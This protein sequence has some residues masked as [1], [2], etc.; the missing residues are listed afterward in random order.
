[1]AASERSSDPPAR[2]KKQA[3]HCRHTLPGVSSSVEAILQPAVAANNSNW[4]LEAG[5]L[6]RPWVPLTGA[7][8]L[9]TLLVASALATAAG[10]SR[11]A[12]TPA[13]S[14]IPEPSPHQVLP[15]SEVGADRTPTQ[16]LLPTAARKRK[17]IERFQND[18]SKVTDVVVRTPS[19]S[20]SNTAGNTRLRDRRSGS[21]G[22]AVSPRDIATVKHSEE[23]DRLGST[24]LT[25]TPEDIR[26]QPFRIPAEPSCNG[27][28]YTS[29]L[30]Y[31]REFR[32]SRS[33]NA[34]VEA[35]ED[36]A[37]ARFFVCN[38]G[39]NHF[40]SVLN[41]ERSCVLSEHPEDACLDQ[42]LFTACNGQDVH[43]SWW[44]FDGR[45][46]V[47][48]DFPSGGCP[49]DG[50]LDVFATAYECAR[51]CTNP[52]YQPCQKPVP[53]P[54]TADLLKLPAFAEVSPDDGRVRCLLTA[55]PQRPEHRCL[56]GSNRFR[57]REACQQVCQTVF[58]AGAD[59][60]PDQV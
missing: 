16:P 5:L 47:P 50:D 24:A 43:R 41:C 58:R 15:L 30:K 29:C 14:H 9:T 52:G 19:D 27:A 11:T 17:T 20:G 26:D 60:T 55:A 40:S 33:A 18:V 13:D 7:A 8:V 51:R 37:A 4:A 46:C 48:W 25:D 22:S 54:C 1:M 12:L 42:A 3:R 38:R 23:P 21:D 49:A 39:P 53:A 56:A 6:S 28:L 32:Y 2:N 34:C 10:L 45:S 36:Q 31:R 57:S 59:T 44:F 35:G